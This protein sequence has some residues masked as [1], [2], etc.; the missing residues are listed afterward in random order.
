M[1][2]RCRIAE[3][4]EMQNF[5][6]VELFRENGEVFMGGTLHARQA[7]SCHIEHFLNVIQSF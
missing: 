6:L 1:A 4:G 3:T 2:S 7:K 5:G